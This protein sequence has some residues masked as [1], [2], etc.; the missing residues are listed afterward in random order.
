[1]LPIDIPESLVAT[2]KGLAQFN[3]NVKVCSSVLM[4]LLGDT[5]VDDIKIG[6]EGLDPVIYD[7]TI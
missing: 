6:E 7:I 2:S 4:F 5:G 1:V 3:G